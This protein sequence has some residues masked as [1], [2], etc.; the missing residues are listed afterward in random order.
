MSIKT[1]LAATAIVAA[2]PA[3]AQDAPKG[4]PAKGEAAFNQCQTCHVVADADGNV[5]AGRASKQGPNL[6]GVIGRQAGT[7]EGFRYGDDLIAAG[8][9][10]LVW[11]EEQFTAYVKDPTKFLRSYLDDRRARGN[12]AFR[13]S[14]EEQ[15]HDLYA[16]LAQ[17]GT[18]PAEGAEAAEDGAAKTD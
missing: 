7:Y 8:E 3:L 1:L 18:V 9:K 10:G 12:M 15:A 11:D 2:A 4:D 17:F 6:Y 16:F 14:K 5:L 13:V